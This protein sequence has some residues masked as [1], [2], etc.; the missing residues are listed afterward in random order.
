[1]ADIVNFEPVKKSL[2]LNDVTIFDTTPFRHAFLVFWLSHCRH[3]IID[4]SPE[5]LSHLWMIPKGITLKNGS[6]FGQ[7]LIFFFS[8]FAIFTF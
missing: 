8:F 1:M 6:M 5:D 3:K 4:L 7:E 2:L